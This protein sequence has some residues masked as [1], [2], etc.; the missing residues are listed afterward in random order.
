MHKFIKFAL[1][2]LHLP[3]CKLLL[4]IF[5]WSYMENIILKSWNLEEKFE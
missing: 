3:L 4:I 5:V 2:V 1:H